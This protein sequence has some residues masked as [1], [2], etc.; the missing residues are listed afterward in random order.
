MTNRPANRL[1]IVNADDYGFSPEINR[2]VCEAFGRGIVTD[3]T[4]LVYSPYAPEGFR[5]AK[6]AGLPVGLHI[7][8]VTSLGQPKSPC[9]GPQGLIC[10][11]LF[12]RERDG[13]PAEPLPAA[14]L[15][16][17]R[18]E[19]R[20]QVERFTSLAGCRPSHLDYHFGLHY[21]PE[22][23]AIYLSVAG[24]Y[25]L[26]VRWG[27]QYAGNN[28][29]PLS[30]ARLCDEFRGLETGCTGL[31]LSLLKRPWQGVLELVCHPGYTTPG[32]L[33]DSYNAEREREFCALVDP[34]VKASLEASGITLVNFG[35]FSAGGG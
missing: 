27:W 33:E 19:I 26:P 2:G 35:W 3:C 20:A 14:A 13:L 6:Q 17:A 10:Q 9:F 29:Y 8:L 31:L 24:E 28:P 34:A 30:P 4:I 32:E 1:L 16:A 7:D 18:D 5:M 25:R 12:R 21:L 15:I 22:L 11:E 23:M